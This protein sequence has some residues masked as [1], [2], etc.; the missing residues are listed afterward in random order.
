MKRLR[1]ILLTLFVLFS[2]FPLYPSQQAEAAGEGTPSST[3]TKR[4][5]TGAWFD[6]GQLIYVTPN[7][8]ASSSTRYGTKAFVIR[9]D[10]TCNST[11]VDTAQC[12]PIAKDS[13][14]DGDIS[15]D[16]LRID[17]YNSAGDY[18][19]SM[20]S[21]EDIGECDYLS[22]FSKISNDLESSPAQR[23]TNAKRLQGEGKCQQAEYGASSANATLV[24]KFVVDR[25]KF[26]EKIV[27]NP[28]FANLAD[29]MT[30]YMNS[31]FLIKDTGG[32]HLTPEYTTLNDIRVAKSWANTSYFRAYYDIQV[33]F[34]GSYPIVMQYLDESGKDIK[35]PT[36]ILSTYGPK[37]RDGYTE[38]MWPAWK[39][40]KSET[41]DGKGIIVPDT[42]TGDDDKT[43]FLVCSYVTRISKPE[44]MDC[45]EQT[46]S[47]TFVRM[48]SKLTE[49]N[50][51]VPIGGEYVR[52][53]YTTDPDCK[54]FSSATVPSKSTVEG[55]VPPDNT[56][57]GQKVSMQVDLQLKDQEDIDDWEKWVVGKKNITINIRTYRSDQTDVLT[58][59]ANTGE[60]PKWSTQGKIPPD[61][62]APGSAIN[63]A[64]GLKV[65]GEELLAYFRNTNGVSKILYEDDLTNYPIPPGGKVSF[66]YNADVFITATDA[67]GKVVEVDC[68]RP[69]SSTEMT[70]FRPEVPPPNTASF[71]SV[72]KYFSEIKEGSPQLSGTSSNETFD[73]MSGIPTT[74]N[75]YF[76]SGGSEFIVDIEVEYISQKSQT[77]SYKSEFNAVV[78]GWA[79][80]PIIGG[81][82]QDVQPPPPA[83]REKID[84]CGAPYKE[85]V[86]S[87]SQQYIK[88]Y[89][90]GEN[91]QPIY[92]T[93]YGW[94][95]KGYDSHVVGHYVDT[96]TQTVTFDYIQIN[97]AVVWKIEKSKVDGMATLVQT[98]EVTASITQGDPTFFYNRAAT[99]TSKEGRLRY[100]L[101][102]DQHDSVYWNEGN[103]DNCLT[104]SKDSGP[105]L[106]QKKF[107]ERRALTTNVTAI[108][109][110]LILQT[111]SGDQSVMYFDKKSNTAKVTEQLDVPIT[112][113]D[114]M[115]TNNPLSAAKWDQLNTIKVGSYNGNFSS[116][117]NKYSG[118][119]TGTVTTIFDSMPAGKIRPSRPAPFMRL[120]ATNL[121]IPD[122]LQNGEYITGTS[123][124][125]FKNVLNDNPKN[126]PTAYPV[127]NNTAYG[128]TGLAY[129]SAYS[130]SHS[131]VNDVVI[132]DPVSVQNA[133]VV[134]LPNSLDQRT[135]P[136]VGNKQEGIAEY[137]RVLDPDYRQNI[138]PNSGAEIVNVNKTVAGWNT[139][140]A[141]GSASAI[142]FTSRT[143]DSWVISGAN[144]FEVNSL[145]SSNTTGGYWK[146]IPIKAN[147]QYKFEGD[148]SC[149]RCEGYFS[150]D[151]Y[152]SDKTFISGGFGSTDKVTN[153]GTVAHK[154]FTFSSPANAA[155]LRIHMI[156][157][158]NK[159]AIS[160]PRDNLFVDNLSLKNMSLQ[161]FVAVE[162]VQVTQEIPNPDYVPESTSPPVAKTFNYTGSVQTFTAP[163]TGT[164]TLEVWGAQGGNST[165]DSRV[166]G[167]LGGYAKGDINLTAGETISIYVGGQSGW[168]GGGAGYGQSSPGGGGTDIRRGGTVLTDRVIVGGGGGGTEYQASPGNGGTMNSGPFPQYG[169]GHGGGLVG[170]TGLGDYAGSDNGAGGTQTS[171]YALGQGGPSVGSHSGGGGGGY[172]GGFNGRTDNNY[173]GG[174]GSGYIGG[175]VGGTMQTGV[176]SGNGAV[177]ISSP[178]TVTPAVGQPIKIITT[179][180]GGSDT[181]P[182]SD[183]YILKP[184]AV[185]PNAPAGGYTPG[186][187]VLLD[188][189]F[190][191]YFPN[192]GDF[193][194]NGQWG[195]AQTTEIR[196]KGFT[197]GMDTTEWTKAKYV[198]FDFNV[199]YNNTMFLANEWIQ[200]PVTSPGWLYDFYVPLANR[201]KISAMVEWK[202]IAI[203]GTIEDGDTPTNKVRY[204]YPRPDSANHSTLK[205][206]Q[207]D[208][209]GRIG[210][211]V[212]EDTGD[213]RFSN[214]F[215]QPLS[216][217]Q[218][219]IPN[220]VKRVNPNIQ[221]KI[222]GDTVDLRGKTVTAGTNYLNTWGLL[223]HIQQKPIPF[224]LSSEKNN[225]DALK[226]Q[227]LRIGYDVL[228]D[229][230]TMGNYYSNLQIIP[231]F[232]HLNLQSG[233]IT[234]VDIYM[235]VNGEYKVI[236]KFGAA[237]PGW[238]ST[239]VY[240]NPVRLDWESQAGRRNV[241]DDEAELTS[242]IAALFAQSGGDTASGK[243]AEPYGSYLYG[244]SQ[245]M[246]L[247]GRNRTYI[248]QDQTYGVNKNPGTKLSMFEYAM[249]AQRWHYSFVL[250]SSAVAVKHDQPAT[251]ANINTLR[252]NT[253]VI[254]MA[255]DIKAIGDTYT[256]QYKAPNGNGSLNLARTSWPLTSIPYPVIAVY[257]ANKSSADDLSITGTH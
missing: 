233:A 245:F 141:T 183:A 59:L 96:W 149:H 229:I 232:Y 88:G 158:V 135:T 177:V 200:L 80:D 208:V 140:V 53:I 248:G 25:E 22:Q 51:P 46:E 249:Q 145:G 181:S 65:S 61:L 197:D 251:Q 34:K 124:V 235:D 243:G 174:G 127:Q 2:G 82:T 74:R 201:E 92:G 111:S 214:L 175:V 77:R 187:F 153:T 192:T 196:G 154:T 159:D 205:R 236:N 218:W 101:E 247:T 116:P 122:T 119:S 131:K 171:G 173:A 134:S 16:Y 15:N 69:K 57:I 217:T 106:E 28:L 178:G 20:W 36:D 230:Q 49:R 7:K 203:N 84:A 40:S 139:W 206:Y 112:N 64:K 138:I 11:N 44:D 109:D 194:G 199:I 148:M 228:S 23:Q 242:R 99:N 67:S 81:F 253:G 121:D 193:F 103:S 93:E 161:E 98:N 237:V 190:Q 172:Y 89:T 188:Y 166:Q 182:P 50:P 75:L 211:M 252:T 126:K 30:V 41:K 256:L 76:A 202:S 136:G 47:P 144:T 255:A 91:P 207:V 24:T 115:W 234:S 18:D 241:K 176:R 60:K 90:T 5:A 48:A 1:M 151:F 189:G 4:Y 185:D 102:T 184:I 220:V 42:L 195:W 70:W 225:I 162:A 179:T 125:F 238:D 58:G 167:G 10:T 221:N 33:E 21:V 73:A 215:K 107:D 204:N 191:L 133:L 123:T 216:P 146:D 198:K 38:G 3:N 72:P 63:P 152:D 68:A 95:Q 128:G 160:S 212:I 32:T 94:D 31:I 117:T 169:G 170:G 35:D 143:G 165:Y 26:E 224:P 164:Y 17:L 142:T 137:E 222:V 227:P 86:Q 100:S 129:T 244:S 223:P 62:D 8:K 110:F 120:M 52:G 85:V 163:S 108:S 43:Y 113:F 114:T 239:S 83:A 9:R 56:T 246:A 29:G 78:N 45:S 157:G 118:G 19:K 186:N 130:P 14:K 150:L 6:D 254:V 213:F 79:M 39:Y 240:A 226:N 219:L 87:K 55:E 180:A 155:Y 168:N 105:V 210:N 147:A 71:F 132:H 156:K 13:N 209:V 257:S 250:P 12:T 66:R 27:E 231:Y 97:K 54:C 104:N 37:K